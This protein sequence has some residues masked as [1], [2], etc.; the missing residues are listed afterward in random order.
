MPGAQG[1]LE[2]A[3]RG[4]SRVPGECGYLLPH[5][6]VD[7]FP[8]GLLGLAGKHALQTQRPL[9]QRFSHT[10]VQVVVGVLGGQVLGGRGMPLSHPV[11]QALAPQIPPPTQ[12][13]RPSWSTDASN[14]HP[15]LAAPHPRSPPTLTITSKREYRPTT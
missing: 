12:L 9:P 10:H 8:Q 14:S 11:A 1:E 4:T 6:P 5:N 7:D 15:F 13:E 2:P 3:V